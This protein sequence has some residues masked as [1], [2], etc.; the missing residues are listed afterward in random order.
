MKAKLVREVY[1]VHCLPQTQQVSGNNV[2]FRRCCRQIIDCKPKK[3]V[4]SE[5][6]E[7]L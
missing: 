2:I 6:K 5:D 3:S 1:I 4:E 7:E